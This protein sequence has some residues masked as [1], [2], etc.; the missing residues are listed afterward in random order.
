MEVYSD[1]M[2]FPC[3]T[4]RN[5]EELKKVIAKC[6]DNTDLILIDTIGKSPRDAV[7]LG[8]MKMLLDACGTLAEVHLVVAATTKSSDINE[9]LKT[10]EPFNYRSIIITKMDETIRCGNVISALS[11]KTKPI[12]YITDG[13]TVPTD[14]RRASVIQ[15]LINLEG[16]KVNRVK[17][18][19]KFPGKGQEQIQQRR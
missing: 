2:Q 1:V 3:F 9:I 8:K 13:Q 11:E 16:F 17:L 15:F 12:S 14:I 19:E 10:F 5:H 4:A 6:S 7:Q 18:E